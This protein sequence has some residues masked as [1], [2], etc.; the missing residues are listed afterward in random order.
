MP[1]HDMYGTSYD[2]SEVGSDRN[3]SFGSHYDASGNC[4]DQTQNRGNNYG[5]VRGRVQNRGRLNTF[6]RDRFMPSSTERL[7][8]RWNEMNYMDGRNMGGPGPNR[9][10]SLFSQ[11]LIP[12]YR[13]YG[14]YGNYGDYDYGMMGMG[15]GRFPGNM[16]GG[17][18]RSRSRVSSYANCEFFLWE[19]LDCFSC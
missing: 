13:D 12:E 9:L 7:S 3:D 8:A 14:D 18:S 4:R 11:A 2:Y 15:I 5:F 1:E 6:N 17:F 16:S 10:P 19:L